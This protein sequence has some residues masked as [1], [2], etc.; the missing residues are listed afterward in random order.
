MKILYLTTVNPHDRSTGGEVATDNIISALNK[1]GH[2]TTTLFYSRINGVE[3]YNGNKS[4]ASRHI[5]SSSAKL[6]SIFWLASALLLNL[7]F[8]TSKY[9][10][11]KYRNRIK[12]AFFTNK[13]DAVFID[14]AQMGW[15]L[16]LIPDGLSVYFISHNVEFNIYNELSNSTCALK[17]L[18]YRREALLIR[19]AELE[20]SL[21]SECTFVLSEEDKAFFKPYTKEV[22]VL[23]M[24]FRLQLTNLSNP[25]PQHKLLCI[26]GTWSWQSNK[27]GLIWFLDKV[28]PHIDADVKIEIAGKGADDLLKRYS[29]RIISKG[30]VPSSESFL[31]NA[32]VIAIPSVSGSG[33]QIKTLEAISIG[34]QVVGTEIAFRGIGDAENDFLIENE[35]KLFA[36]SINSA[37]KIK[38]HV[39]STLAKTRAESFLQ[40][41]NELTPKS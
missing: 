6:Q 38:G 35:P 34:T 29:P 17:K 31:S 27:I 37:I 5:E 2:E 15:A 20:L 22:T 18:I 40:I 21:K 13:Y 36:Q 26:I 25:K 33:I 9:I 8:S 39:S 16:E 11:R 10:S 3:F 32:K 30:F 19:K 41:F 24:P 14:H 7:P 12:N 28:L 4:V 23:P 1:A